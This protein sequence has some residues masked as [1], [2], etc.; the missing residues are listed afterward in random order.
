MSKVYIGFY[1]D[2]FIERFRAKER[3]IDSLAPSSVVLYL[4]L[5]IASEIVVNPG[6]FRFI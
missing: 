5:P 2:Q 6:Q 1:E 4:F 3:N